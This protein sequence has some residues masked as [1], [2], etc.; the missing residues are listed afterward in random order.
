MKLS[1]NVELAKDFL[2]DALRF[3]QSM[4]GVSLIIGGGLAAIGLEVWLGVSPLWVIISGE[5]PFVL[6]LVLSLPGLDAME[7]QYKIWVWGELQKLPD[8][9]PSR[10]KYSGPLELPGP[11]VGLGDK[12]RNRWYER[13]FQD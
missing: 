9:H 11:S 10:K 5:V 12:F 13:L 1:F 2:L 6:L 8:D 7:M 3:W 4:L